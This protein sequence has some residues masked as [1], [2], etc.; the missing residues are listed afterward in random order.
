MPDSSR[1]K[2]EL[3]FLVPP[4]WISR[5]E[6][7]GWGGSLWRSFLAATLLAASCSG[8]PKDTPTSLSDVVQCIEAVNGGEAYGGCGPIASEEFQIRD[9]P[10]LGGEN[11]NLSDYFFIYSP[12]VRRLATVLNS[13]PGRKLSY[14]LVGH[15]R[16]PA[17]DEQSANA[18]L[19]ASLGYARRVAFILRDLGV[20]EG[21]L[22]AEGRGR[23]MPPPRDGVKVWV[24][25]EIATPVVTKYGKI[26]ENRERSA[27]IP[28]T[29]SFEPVV[30]FPSGLAPA[31]PTSID[32]SSLDDAFVPDSDRSCQYSEAATEF[33]KVGILDRSAGILWA[34]LRV[35]PVLTA[36][37]AAEQPADG[38]WRLW[39]DLWGEAPDISPSHSVSK[40]GRYRHPDHWATRIRLLQ[41]L[42]GGE[43][44]DPIVN[45][46]ARELGPGC[47]ANLEGLKFRDALAVRMPELL[48]RLPQNGDDRLALAYS[49]N[50]WAS[51]F[52]LAP[53]LELCL[54]TPGG[55]MLRS[56]GTGDYAI[57][58]SGPAPCLP[59]LPM[60]SIQGGP[61]QGL[62]SSSG[63]SSY[64]SQLPDPAT[65]LALASDAAT[66]PLP[67]HT[68][69]ANAAG[70]LSLIMPN[71]LKPI[72]TIDQLAIPCPRQTPDYDG[73]VLLLYDRRRLYCNETLYVRVVVPVV[74]SSESS[75]LP[76]N[77]PLFIRDIRRSAHSL[78]SEI[79]M[80][81]STNTDDFPT[82]NEIRRKCRK[83]ADAQC[84]TLRWTW[85]KTPDEWALLGPVVPYAKVTDVPDNSSHQIAPMGLRLSQL[86][87][88]ISTMSSTG[89]RATQWGGNLNEWLFEN[90]A[91]VDELFLDDFLM[92]WPVARARRE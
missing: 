37:A 43:G 81:Y 70:I 73:N 78:P 90:G 4:L 14:R 58:Y 12:E 35:A 27:L 6:P 79:Y 16:R 50:S 34:R 10:D 22:I 44:S 8:V 30:Y 31:L 92:Q 15:V 80:D 11:A 55:A 20:S 72:Q 56:N 39:L 18:E 64:G 26:A 68:S 83:E 52:D 2:Q 82:D 38:P 57:Q 65:R 69:L 47:L 66:L 85:R 13:D 54:E 28:A 67:D 49:V 41:A 74:P 7:G 19:T 25:V 32:L 42:A 9:H 53:G 62:P 59:I 76:T 45:R 51:A 46:L 86:T 84:V 87:N 63:G 23:D 89:L 48:R 24:T 5:Q 17:N 75:K 77:I 60:H 1:C 36:D 29:D 61:S 88:A 3:K 21:A 33:P 71:T 40:F 91:V